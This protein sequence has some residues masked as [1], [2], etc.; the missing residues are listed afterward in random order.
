MTAARMPMLTAGIIHCLQQRKNLSPCFTEPPLQPVLR[1][2]SSLLQA[3]LLMGRTLLLPSETLI[4]NSLK[5][6]IVIVGGG[7]GGSGGENDRP[8]KQVG[9][10]VASVAPVLSVSSR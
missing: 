5:I 8:A 7:I 6:K 9:S 10:T 1:N 3:C 4:R 2:D